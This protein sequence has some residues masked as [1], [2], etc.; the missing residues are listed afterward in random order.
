[1]SFSRFFIDRPIFAAVIS[2]IIIIAGAVA[3]PSLPV[4]Q[5]PEIAPPQ[6]T[7]SATFAGATAETL[8]ETVAAPIEEAV[9]GVEDMIYMQSSSTG[10]GVVSINVTFAQGTDVDQAQVLVQNRVATAEP[11]L[12]QQVRDIGVTVRKSSPDLLMVVNLLSPDDSLD[13]QYISNYAVLQLNDRLLRLDGVGNV[14]VFG[15]RDYNMRIWVDPG[16]AAN[17]NLTVDEIIGA[18]RAQNVQAAAGAIGQP[19][20]NTGGNAFE[21]GIQT[22]G[23]LNSTEEFGNIIVN[24][25]ADGGLVRLRDVARIELGAESYRTNAYLNDDE[26]AALA[27]TQ[28]P[29]ANALTTADAVLAELDA[30][31]ADF[32]PGLDFNIAYNPTEYVRASIG[33]VQSTL[34]QALV[35][36]AVVMLLFLQSWRAA[37]LPIL[38][39][40]VSLAGA[41]A[42]MALFGF[43]V[44]NLSLFGL[45]LAIGIV[46]DDTIVVVENIARVMKEDD[47]GPLEAAKRTMDEVSGALVA[48]T[49]VL[50]GVFIPTAFVPGISGQFYR[51]FALTIVSATTVS[52]IVSLTLS[53][54]LAARL[55]LPEMNDDPNESRE[56]HKG[57]R[58]W[59]N[60]YACRFNNGLDWL[61][62]KYA[63]FSCR[64]V[65]ALTAV[66]ICYAVLIG[67]TAWRFYEV[68]TGFIPSQDQGY[69]I[70]AIEL[71]PGSSLQRTD[72]VLQDVIDLALANEDTD[73]AVAFAG[74]NGATF[75]NA[76]N[77]AA[78]FV[79]LKDFGER[80]RAPEVANE[81]RE[82]FGKITAGN[83]LVIEPPAVSGIGTGGG[84][85]MM[86]EDRGGQGYGALEKVTQQMMGVANQEEGL[87]SVFSTYNTRTPRLAANVDRER[88][89]QIGV[90]VE[91]V[92]STLGTYLGS[93]YINDF[94]YLGRTF[95]VTAQGDAPYRD[96]R[97][98]IEQLRTRSSSGAM[99]PL[100]AVMDLEDESGP[101]RVVRFNLYPSAELQGET[102]QGFSSG[103]SLETMERLAD[104]TLP[105]G[106]AYE[107]TELAFQQK[108]AGNTIIFI[109]VLSVVFVFLLLAAQ[110]ESVVLPFAVILIVPLCL[111]AAIVGVEIMG[112]ANNILV[113]IGFIVLVALS[114]KNAILIVEFAKQNEDDGDDLLTA[115]EKAAKQRLRP[116]LMTSMAFILGVFPLVIAS[117]AGAEMRQ[118]LGVAVFFGMIGVTIFGTMFTP[119]LYVLARKMGDA[120]RRLV[121]KDEEDKGEKEV[122]DDGTNR[123]T[124]PA[125]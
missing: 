94:N 56:T 88:A 125:E 105:S 8:A 65:R 93:T 76:S 49:L 48:T 71:P 61:T 64:S 50:W 41:I 63:T 112:L 80:K 106:F 102:A 23:R 24:R 124:E 21:L 40:P 85:K 62:E 36:V 89:E 3:Y 4:S 123:A 92:F 120:G 110:Y 6:V 44:N 33:A 108:Q 91:S 111:L 98:D 67:L 78:A 53:P 75:T 77:A 38:A 10:D 52:T 27:I 29:G 51:Q 31:R 59:I 104:E 72:E 26:M 99:V 37:I 103:Q 79:T 46:V 68:P 96:D 30:A 121:G 86:I 14:Q 55:L 116:I 114:T 117:G 100:G 35:L 87:T 90:P 20:F 47:V 22:D 101:Y 107:W 15:G 57:W 19:P 12:P 25:A 82:A 39:I 109:F 97:P 70:T 7:I 66:M 83:V 45:I 73:Q 16:L 43:S 113:Q 13:R 11:R 42:G 18:V 5:Y 54:A 119:A 84:F 28:L 69:L 2:I 1:M 60:R 17:R 118:A 32:P 74:F 34:I 122:K 9:N 95:R 58:T 115:A 81:L